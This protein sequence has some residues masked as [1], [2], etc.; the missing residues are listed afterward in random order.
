MS[1]RF[2]LSLHALERTA[3]AAG[4]M[5]T[6]SEM[7]LQQRILRAHPHLFAQ[8]F[9]CLFQLRVGGLI[10]LAIGVAGGR[11]S[12]QPL[13][14][15]GA[16]RIAEEYLDGTHRSAAGLGETHLATPG[17]GLAHARPLPEAL[18]TDDDQEAVALAEAKLG[19]ARG[20]RGEDHR[21]NRHPPSAV[22]GW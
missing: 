22:R 6:E 12:C 18:G 9:G 3:A 2:E 19:P 13:T 21:L 1:C 16:A 17:L 10:A 14:G 11:L 15:G 4:W 20:T 7:R 8:G 5:T